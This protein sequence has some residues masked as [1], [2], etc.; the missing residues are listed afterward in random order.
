MKRRPQ[1]ALL[2]DRRRL[3]LQDGPIDLIVEAKG[4]EVDVQAAY[5]VFSFGER[6]PEAIRSLIRQTR[7]AAVLL[8]GLGTTA[9]RQDAP[10]R[11]TFIPPYLIRSV[12][13]G[14]TA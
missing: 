4:K 12:Q 9:L 7:P 6:D 14:E 5:D 8:V 1:I 11:P 3:H 2:A 10:A 13:D